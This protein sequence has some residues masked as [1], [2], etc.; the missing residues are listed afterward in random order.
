MKLS[1]FR[2]ILLALIV[3][4]AACSAEDHEAVTVV[5]D[6]TVG[7]TAFANLGEPT[8]TPVATAT[9][10]VVPTPVSVEVTATPSATVTVL[11]DNVVEPEIEVA[12]VPTANPVDISS[13]PVDANGVIIANSMI[14]PRII[15]LEELDDLDPKPV[16]CKDLEEY[17]N[18][19][20][21][22]WYADMYCVPG[23]PPGTA[24]CHGS[25]FEPFDL[26]L[27]PVVIDEEAIF[28]SDE[29]YYI[30]KSPFA[31]KTP[32][33]VSGSLGPVGNTGAEPP[34]NG[35]LPGLD[36]R[37]IALWY[38]NRGSL[39][40]TYL[41]EHWT[42]R[43]DDEPYDLCDDADML[44]F[45][46]PGRDAVPGPDSSYNEFHILESSLQGSD[47]VLGGELTES[48]RAVIERTRTEYGVSCDGHPWSPRY[49][50]VGPSWYADR[51]TQAY[52]TPE[53][54][55]QEI[56][57]RN[58]R[59]I[60]RSR[61]LYP[62]DNTL[63]NRYIAGYYG[64]GRAYDVGRQFPPEPNDNVV[65][66]EQGTTIA[67]G[68]LRGLVHNQSQTLFA[69]N[70]EVTAI[71]VDENENTVSGSWSW[72]LTMQPGEFAPFEI[73]DWMGSADASQISFDIAANLSPYL[74][75]TRSFTMDNGDYTYW[76]TT[77]ISVGLMEELYPEDLVD[78]KVPDYWETGYERD[79]LDFHAKLTL[80]TS[81]PSL[82]NRIRKL[83]LA[84]EDIRAFVMFWSS[85]II[86]TD[87]PYVAT[88]QMTISDIVDITPYL[89]GPEPL[90]REF[91][92]SQYR[93]VLPLADP[94]Q[95][96]HVWIGAANPAPAQ[97]LPEVP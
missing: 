88:S 70:V 60:E 53:R 84:K 31:G 50:A 23:C 33:D 29:E 58:P 45:L 76:N 36:D 37:D 65:I 55:L 32:G 40:G 71:S 1:H 10:L 68:V 91:V 30:T 16:P 27:V 93:I 52:P 75:I 86:P 9:V 22:L 11:S 89:E 67:G 28:W 5:G 81:H 25:P 90:D 78:G 56:I 74:D 8:V 47:V 63:F 4:F 94:S 54:A 69:R 7:D 61:K 6:T 66:E 72:P 13:L 59:G 48:D 96:R 34:A 43:V 26:P 46:P 62:D 64:N 80:P 18:P 12:A 41:S 79:T 42:S 19:D 95:L 24:N 17:Q 38:D 21:L 35:V 49:V 92:F 44:R 77:D 97:D 39:Y 3:F 20:D 51:P 85:E 14:I 73:E 2:T 83:D 57:Q 87:D 82:K 15:S